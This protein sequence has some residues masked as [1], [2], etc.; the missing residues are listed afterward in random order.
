MQAADEL[1]AH[2]DKQAGKDSFTGR[3]AGVAARATAT[4][5][6]DISLLVTE[7]PFPSTCLLHKEVNCACVLQL[8]AAPMQVRAFDW[9]C[10]PTDVIA[11]APAAAL[12]L[13]LPRSYSR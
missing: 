1:T 8:L 2:A 11:T 12:S 10:C 4:F 3:R 5:S 7:V 9:C 13:L 6:Y